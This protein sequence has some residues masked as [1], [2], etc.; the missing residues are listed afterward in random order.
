MIYGLL[1]KNLNQH[2]KTGSL[3]VYLHTMKHIFTVKI[4]MV[5]HKNS[6]SLI[7]FNSV[8]NLSMA[9]LNIQLN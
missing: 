1:F 7:T 3:K 4:S 8:L 9:H 6:D 2:Y 5:N